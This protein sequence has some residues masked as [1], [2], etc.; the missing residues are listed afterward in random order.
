MAKN[1]RDVRKEAVAR[2]LIDEDKVAAAL[3]QIRQSIAETAE[4]LPTQTDF[5]ARTCAAGGAAA[6]PSLPE[7]TF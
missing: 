3:E 7:F 6:P 1:W 4:Q 5:I 2:G